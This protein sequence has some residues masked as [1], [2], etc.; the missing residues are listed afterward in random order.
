MERLPGTWDNL[1][2]VC[3]GTSWNGVWFPEK[4]IAHRLT[5]YGPV[6]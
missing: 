5:E 2:V 1:I 3:A 6:L 4:H